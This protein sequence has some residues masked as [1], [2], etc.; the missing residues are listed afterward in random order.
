M[1]TKYS[2]AD[3]SVGQME[4]EGKAG[5]GKPGDGGTESDSDAADGI[6]TGI[7]ESADSSGRKKK[8]KKSKKGDGKKDVQ[9]LDTSALLQK[10]DQ[11]KQI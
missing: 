8:P 5:G 6:G 9:T 11:R 4:T 2:A 7:S 3:F 10:R 1:R